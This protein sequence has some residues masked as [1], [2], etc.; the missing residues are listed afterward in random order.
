MWKRSVR[1]AIRSTKRLH[2]GGVYLQYARCISRCRHSC[3]RQCHQLQLKQ[4]ELLVLAV[5]FGWIFARWALDSV[6]F[7]LLSYRSGR[8]KGIQRAVFSALLQRSCLQVHTWDLQAS[9]G[10]NSG[11]SY[12]DLL[13]VPLQHPSSSMFNH[14]SRTSGSLTRNV[15]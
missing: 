9:T 14:W 7:L 6:L 2:T 12:S 4:R 15:P 10:I 3:F 1:T 11:L 13:S 5:Q 8:S